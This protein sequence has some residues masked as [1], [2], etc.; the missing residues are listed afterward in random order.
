MAAPSPEKWTVLALLNWTRGHLERAGAQSPR[1]AAEVLL[2]AVLGCKRIELYTRYDYVPAE[3]QLSRFREL[4]RRAAQHEPV[5]YL[6]GEKEFYSL[7][8]Q[9]TPDV[10]VPRPESEILVEQA[11]GLLR[12]LG[13]A[14]T[15]WDVCTGSG[16][17][18]VATAKQ[19]PDLRVLA[20]DLSAAAVEVARRNVALHHLE[21]RV[22]VCATDLLTP[23]AE[24]KHAAGDGP[25]GC[26]AP[27]SRS[28]TPG[29]GT[30]AG[31]QTGGPVSTPYTYAFDVITA[32]P[33]YIPDA[34]EVAPEVA[35]EPKI[36]LRGG[37]DGLQ[38]IRR[39]IADAPR[40]L[41]PGGA[42][43]MEF[44]IDQSP[45]VRDLIGAA[46]AFQEPKVFTDHQGLD[47]A[48]VAV[49]S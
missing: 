11:V 6:L 14:G 7:P 10:L 30:D 43:V 24:W 38:L 13:R 12:A 16:C 35:H 21:D 42:L 8:F 36:A 44:G 23:P 41:R 5:A 25:V 34:A 3:D 46:G 20:T 49:K 28:C 48:V 19:V 17:V 4:I 2:A 40:F 33:P 22:Q 29:C 37:A 15:M 31:V 27:V 9:V 26:A 1:L 47:R 32:N 18:A 45:A 39:V